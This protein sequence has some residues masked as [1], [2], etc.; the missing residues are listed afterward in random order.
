MLTSVAIV[1]LYDSD[2][3]MLSLVLMIGLHET[4]NDFALAY[5]L[6]SYP[7]KEESISYNILRLQFQ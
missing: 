3:S 2:R 7:N 4:V 5:Q 1:T 6:N